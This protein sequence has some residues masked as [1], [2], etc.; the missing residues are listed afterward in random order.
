[1]ADIIYIEQ[2]YFVG[3]NYFT[4]TADASATFTPTTA[5]F[6]NDANTLLL[7][8]ANGTNASTTFTDDNA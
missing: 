4:Y 7:I 5:A 8:H 2:G 6:V 1:M 3:D